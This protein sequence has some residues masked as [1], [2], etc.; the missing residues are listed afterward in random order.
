MVIVNEANKGDTGEQV[1]KLKNLR[2]TRN[3][4]L[5][6]EDYIKILFTLAIKLRDNLTYK[7]AL[8]VAQVLNVFTCTPSRACSKYY[9]IEICNEYSQNLSTHNVCIGCGGYLGVSTKKNLK[10]DKCLLRM[11]CE[12]SDS[13]FLCLSIAD[14]VRDIFDT[15]E[16]HNLYSFSRQKINNFAIEDIYNGDLYKKV[17]KDSTNTISLNFSVDGTPIFDSSNH[18]AYSV[19]CTINELSLAKRKNHVL[20]AS[21]WYGSS[22]P[23]NMNGYLT[24]FVNEAKK[25]Y[26]EGIDYCY[27]GQK[28]NKKVIVLMAVRDSVARPQY[29]ALLSLTGNM[30]V[31]FVSILIKKLPKVMFILEFIYWKV[32]MLLPK[33]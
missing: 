31:D 11:K 16:A 9:W 19:L 10:C 24:P 4:K 18:S 32:Q 30:A 13:S 6:S 14:Q 25:L 33:D 28:Y 21:I 3:N 29:D 1:K 15:S 17:M 27:Q 2:S 12:S 20:L 22:K 7:A 5:T 23:K 8:H 26:T